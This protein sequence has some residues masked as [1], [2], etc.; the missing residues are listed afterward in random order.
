MPTLSARAIKVTIVLDALE[1]FD[2]L[3]QT[4]ALA[5]TR[6]PFAIDVDGWLL[7][8][9]FSAKSVRRALAT[10]HHHG[11]QNVAVIIQGKL[12][13]GDVIAEAGLVAQLRA[14]RPES[15]TEA[16]A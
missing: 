7:R 4:V 2:V 6:V 9:D 16:V 1:V 3:K 8:T 10:L 12:G 13:R 14:P 11:V 5:A 15:A